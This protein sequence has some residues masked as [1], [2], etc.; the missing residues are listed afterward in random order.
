MPP[1]PLNLR[2][3][4]L[5]RQISIRAVFYRQS[6]SLISK[7]PLQSKIRPPF[8]NFWARACMANNLPQIGDYFGEQLLSSIFIKVI[9]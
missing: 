4:F 7:I 8:K 1:D 5:Q 6:N 9:E 2:L 3:V